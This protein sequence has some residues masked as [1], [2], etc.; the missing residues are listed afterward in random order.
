MKEIFFG[1]EHK[2]NCQNIENCTAKIDITT[3]EER[4]KGITRYTKGRGNCEVDMESEKCRNE[5]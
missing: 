3:S 5:K 4:A 1:C 2:E